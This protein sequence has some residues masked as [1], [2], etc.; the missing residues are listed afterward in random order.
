MSKKRYGVK[1]MKIQ[2]SRRKKPDLT[3]S[4]TN[5]CLVNE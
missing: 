2:T 4:G 1:N 5:E 3:E